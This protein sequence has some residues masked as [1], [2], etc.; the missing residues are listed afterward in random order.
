MFHRGVALL[1][2][3]SYPQKLLYYPQRNTSLLDYW[4]NALSYLMFTL[5]AFNFIV[6]W[7]SSLGGEDRISTVNVI[8]FVLASGFTIL[9]YLPQNWFEFLLEGVFDAKFLNSQS[10][11]SLWTTRYACFELMFL[12]RYFDCLTMFSV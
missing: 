8:C 1:D 6:I 2:W 7:M 9:L 11:T 4:I 3:F 5:F 12:R 10:A